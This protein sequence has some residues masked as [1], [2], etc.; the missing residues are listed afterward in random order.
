[1]YVG[2]SLAAYP[3]SSPVLRG[4]GGSNAALLPDPRR[5]SCGSQRVLRYSWLFDFLTK[6]EIENVIQE[7]KTRE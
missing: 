7:S 2:N 5:Q 1:M 4:R 3:T 6:Q